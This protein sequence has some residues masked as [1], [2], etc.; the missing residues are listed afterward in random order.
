[1]EQ[2][3]YGGF[4]L[5]LPEEF[6]KTDAEFNVSLSYRIKDQWDLLH[7]SDNAENF[8]ISKGDLGEKYVEILNSEVENNEIHASCVIIKDANEL[9]ILMKDELR[10]FGTLLCVLKKE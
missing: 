1:M 9:R 8:V 3:P 10:P 4:E 7:V 6:F 2:V 5:E